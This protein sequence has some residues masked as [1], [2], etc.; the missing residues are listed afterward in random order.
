LDQIDEK[1]VRLLR[2]DGRMSN[3][4]LAEAVG[5]SPSACLR[6][7]RLLEHSG[8][9]RGYAAIVAAPEGNGRITFVVEIALE[10]Q[11]EEFLARFEAAV[12]KLPEVQECLLMS[13]RA[14]YLLR[15]EAADQADFERIH[16]DQLAR[17]P[18]VAHIKSSFAIRHVIRR[19]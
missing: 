3:A 17:L 15:V 8:V 11:T 19:Q 5:L 6:R 13:G 10:R 12:C 7:L 2:T 4:K 1:L 18:G 16:R 9:I 14:D